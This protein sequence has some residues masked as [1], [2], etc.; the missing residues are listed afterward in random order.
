MPIHHRNVSIVNFAWGQKVV[1][2]GWLPAADRLELRHE[3]R[4][5]NVGF[6]QIEEMII[7]KC[8]HALIFQ[9][10]SLTE[11]LTVLVNESTDEE[12]VQ[13]QY[14]VYQ[15]EQSNKLLWSVLIFMTSLVS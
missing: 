1:P 10:L 14:K 4:N 11:T 6:I 13:N 3:L 8:L 9:C 2:A 5:R 15:E 12:K 7:F